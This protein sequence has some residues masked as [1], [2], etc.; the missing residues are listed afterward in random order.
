VTSLSSEDRASSGEVLLVG[1]VGGCSEVSSDTN[2]LEDVGEGDELG[3][4]GNTKVV[5]ASGGGVV[6]G[7]CG[8]KVSKMDR[9]RLGPISRT[10]DDCCQDL[11]MALLVDGDLLEVSV[12]VLAVEA[13]CCKVGLGV[14][15]EALRVKGRLEVFQCKR[16]VEDRAV[17]VGG[18][19]LLY[20]SW[21][22]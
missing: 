11:D 19:P 21:S 13:S 2:T 18:S 20:R 6:A 15:L 3:S 9:R 17:L 8:R 10:F 4:V 14:V 16:V 7:S 5:G 1:N 22:C 12:E